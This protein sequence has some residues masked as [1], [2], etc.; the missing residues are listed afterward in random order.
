MKAWE[1]Y[2]RSDNLK[3]QNDGEKENTERGEANT[4]PTVPHGHVPV[5]NCLLR[6]YADFSAVSQEWGKNGI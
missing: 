3:S 6:S 2:Q 4:T 1:D 5:S